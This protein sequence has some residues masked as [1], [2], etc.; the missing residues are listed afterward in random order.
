[1]AE[2][3]GNK[4]KGP[5]P[6][7][8]KNVAVEKIDDKIKLIT[9]EDISVYWNSVKDRDVDSFVKLLVKLRER[10]LYV[11]VDDRQIELIFELI[12]LLLF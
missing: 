9:D 4:G 1:M 6:K 12:F 11:P 5:A 10:I 7:A 3:E 8:P 2:D